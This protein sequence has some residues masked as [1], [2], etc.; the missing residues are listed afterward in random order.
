[1][2]H[3]FCRLKNRP[4]AW[5]T[6]CKPCDKLYSWSYTLDGKQHTGPACNF[7][8]LISYGTESSVDE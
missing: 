4:V 5:Q 2:S 1:M 6:D 3:V 8:M 7:V